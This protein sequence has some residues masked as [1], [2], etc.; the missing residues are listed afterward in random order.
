MSG[1]VV[2]YLLGSGVTFVIGGPL[3]KVRRGMSLRSWELSITMRAI[4]GDW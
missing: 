4:K 3:V 1:F 2:L